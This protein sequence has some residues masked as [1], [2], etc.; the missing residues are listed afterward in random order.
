MPAP[1]KQP[2]PKDDLSAKGE[3]LLPVEEGP[4]VE[5]EV[6]RGYYPHLNPN[7]TPREWDEPPWGHK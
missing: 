3:R 5:A 1:K 6:L 7:V 2:K 4:D